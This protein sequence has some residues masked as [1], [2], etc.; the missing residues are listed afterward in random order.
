M[1]IYEGLI[2]K[3]IEPCLIYDKYLFNMVGAE[4]KLIELGMNTIKLNCG[5]VT[6]EVNDDIFDEYFQPVNYKEH[7]KINILF[8]ELYSLT[9]GC[10]YTQEKLDE[11]WKEIS[12]LIEG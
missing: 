8:D 3:Q 11:L 1:D 6:I 12:Y 10:N 7:G 9:R 5:G 4:F 2:V